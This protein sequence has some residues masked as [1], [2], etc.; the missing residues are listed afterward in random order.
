MN[1]P[2]FQDLCTK[3]EEQFHQIHGKKCDLFLAFHFLALLLNSICNLRT[4][5]NITISK[6][7][8]A[9]NLDY[10]GSLI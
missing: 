5:E 9:N 7:K 4:K 3:K 10:D 2:E 1:N 6:A 8:M